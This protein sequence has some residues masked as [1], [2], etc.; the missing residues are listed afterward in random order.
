MKA[1][2]NTKFF[3][4]LCSLEVSML[5]APF[6]QCISTFVSGYSCSQNPPKVLWSMPVWYP[7]TPSHNRWAP[8][9]PTRSYPHSIKTDTHTDRRDWLLWLHQSNLRPA[10]VLP[11]QLWYVNHHNLMWAGWAALAEPLSLCDVGTLHRLIRRTAYSRWEEAVRSLGGLIVTA[12]EIVSISCCNIGD[13]RVDPQRVGKTD[14]V[15]NL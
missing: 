3:Q 1:Y 5:L 4:I 9:L 6:R 7:H 2:D 8:N 13:N 12:R 15:F 14:V 11:G 10:L